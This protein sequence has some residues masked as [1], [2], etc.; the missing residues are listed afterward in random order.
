MTMRIV[1]VMAGKAL[2]REAVAVTSNIGS[3]AA[4]EEAGEVLSPLWRAVKPVE[5]ADIQATGLFRNLGSAEGKY[6]SM[7][8]EGAA[9]YAKQ[10]FYGFKDPAYILIRSV[11]PSSLLQQLEV[12]AVDRGVPAIVIPNQALPGLIPQILYYCPL[13]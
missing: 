12:Q 1:G 2:G 5:L 4:T 6:F 11:V 3:Q 7:T 8:A 9:S 13:P 10:A